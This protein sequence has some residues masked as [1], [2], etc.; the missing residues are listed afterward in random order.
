MP[1]KTNIEKKDG[2]QSGAKIENTP[3]QKDSM[4]KTQK[5]DLDIDRDPFS[6]AYIDAPMVT[7][8][9][10]VWQG[11]AAHA[12]EDYEKGSVTIMN[13]RGEILA[14]VT[15]PHLDTSLFQ[16]NQ[17]KTVATTPGA[18]MP[19]TRQ[20]TWEINQIK[21]ELT[22]IQEYLSG[23]SE[24]EEL[25]EVTSETESAAHVAGLSLAGKNRQIQA[26]LT[27][28]NAPF[29]NRNLSGLYAPGSLIKILITLLILEKDLI[30]P[31]KTFHCPGYWDHNG[32]RFYCYTKKGHGDINLENAFIQSCAVY[33]YHASSIIDINIVKEYA[34]KLG[35]G[36]RFLPLFSES[37][38][39]YIPHPQDCHL[40]QKKY[41][42]NLGD[43]IQ[44]FI[45]QGLW[46]V[47]PVQLATMMAR[48]LTNKAIVPSLS[49]TALS[50]YS[51]SIN[52]D[53]LTRILTN[54][55]IVPSLSRT[56]L[57]PYSESINPD[58]LTRIL[59][60][61]A[62][63]PSLSRTTLSPYSESINPAELNLKKSTQAFL[64]NNLRK[65][66]TEGTVQHNHQQLRVA[67]KTGTAQLKKINAHLRLIKQTKG[68][69]THLIAKEDQDNSLFLG[70]YPHTNPEFVMCV[71]VENGRWGSEASWSVMLKLIQGYEKWPHEK[72]HSNKG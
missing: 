28:K 1:T 7:T 31:K 62:I 36:T 11:L 55:A 47:S 56:T 54:K 51:E 17:L 43:H 24:T 37:A 21:E 33:Y 5:E 41:Q 66:I 70:Y 58:E 67:G 6:A 60:N 69:V 48:I 63:V 18:S 71:I 38:T 2:D 59:T 22:R 49:R 10:L 27:N 3:Q 53:E 14:S 13:L 72:R 34:L 68:T 23:T 50:P 61:K 30:D 42:W 32:Y 39:G 25:E 40:K 12:L 35:L 4:Q 15:K 16:K 57:S 8:I 45:G 9:D 29:F 19:E 26:A 44:T 52:P 20:D 64:K 46:Q 65:V